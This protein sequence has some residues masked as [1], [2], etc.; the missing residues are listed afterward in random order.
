MASEGPRCPPAS[1]EPYFLEDSG[2]IS[3][4]NVQTVLHGVK[5]DN[6]QCFKSW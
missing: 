1:W 6:K 2:R 3:S 5:G 4:I